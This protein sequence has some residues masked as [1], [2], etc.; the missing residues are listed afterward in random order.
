MKSDVTRTVN[1]K[2]VNGR[3]VEFGTTGR[4]ATRIRSRGNRW[5]RA[6]ATP[7]V[8]RVKR[9]AAGT[10][11]T[12][13]ERTTKRERS[14]RDEGRESTLNGVRPYARPIDSR[15]SVSF[16]IFFFHF[17]FFILRRHAR[18][19]VLYIRYGGRAE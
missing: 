2:T 8:C 10:R 6:R 11:A 17:F 3:R 4:N 16:E 9:S 1:R 7:G 15:R 18:V 5:L 12:G 13:R 14:R 19:R